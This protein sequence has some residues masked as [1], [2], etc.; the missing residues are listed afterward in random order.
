MHMGG[1]HAFFLKAGAPCR[2]MMIPL[3]R[4]L[5]HS[6]GVQEDYGE[7]AFFFLSSTVYGIAKQTEIR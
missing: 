6:A 4:A 2:R 1:T 7:H 5:R 3:R